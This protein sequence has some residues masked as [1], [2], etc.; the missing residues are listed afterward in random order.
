[1]PAHK[2]FPGKQ[3]LVTEFGSQIIEHGSFKEWPPRL[4]DLTPLDFFLWGYLKEQAYATPPQTL[5]DLEWHIM[6]YYCCANV[7][8]LVLQRVEC[9]IQ[10]RIQ[11]CIAVEGDK[12]EHLK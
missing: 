5:Q 1:M 11:T 2:T 9:E 4:P 8:S 12:L 10:T 6:D 7:S 3:Y